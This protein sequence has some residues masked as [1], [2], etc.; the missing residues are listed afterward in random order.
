MRGYKLQLESLGHTVEAR[1]LGPIH[2]LGEIK[3]LIGA[4]EYPDAPDDVIMHGLAEDCLAD[5]AKCAA[6]ILF[7]EE[8]KEAD[9]P[10]FGGRW[11]EMGAALALKN[12]VHV[13]GPRGGN[14][15]CY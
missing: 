11:V 12:Q 4:G 7:T 10:S 9:T 1:W 13:V 6:L 3:V 14:V 2:A 15:F 8:D 5:V